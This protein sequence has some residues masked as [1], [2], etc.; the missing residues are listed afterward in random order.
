MY[1]STR[2]YLSAYR[3]SLP[4]KPPHYNWDNN[5]L[6]ISRPWYV[7]VSQTVFFHSTA[8]ISRIAPSIIVF[9]KCLV[10]QALVHMGCATMA[11]STYNRYR[12]ISTNCHTPSST[13]SNTETMTHSAQPD[14]LFT[15]PNCG[16]FMGP[17]HLPA[18]Q[19]ESYPHVHHCMNCKL[20]QA[21]RRPSLIQHSKQVGI[22]FIAHLFA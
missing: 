20:K 5:T 8:T 9:S 21:C 13:R 10:L 19:S 15:N 6:T 18:Q 17:C 2:E 22:F 11:T 14:W 1:L 16:H 7:C 4:S 12:S 3:S